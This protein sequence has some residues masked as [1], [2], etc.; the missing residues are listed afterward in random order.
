MTLPINIGHGVTIEFWHPS[1]SADK[2]GGIIE[3]HPG[4][5]G[6]PCSGS[7]SF[8]GYARRDLNPTWRVVSLDPLT[9]E[10]SILCRSC[11]H[12]GF[13]RN[14]RWEPA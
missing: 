6:Q 8:E 7:L 11:G 2:P 3:T 13:I 14:G 10:P 5:D 1:E 9:L 12:H 4:P